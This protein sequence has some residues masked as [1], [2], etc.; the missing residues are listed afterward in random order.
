LR[1]VYLPVVG[2]HRLGW[3]TARVCGSVMMH[4][5]YSPVVRNH[6]LGWETARV[7]EEQNPK[8]FSMIAG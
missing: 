1:D 4:C 6:R 3:E 2:N 5:G 7:D 8:G